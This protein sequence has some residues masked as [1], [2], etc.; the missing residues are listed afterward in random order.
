[1]LVS[2]LL[3]KRMC[4]LSRDSGVNTNKQSGKVV[5]NQVDLTKKLLKIVV[6]LDINK[7]ST[8]SSTIPLVIGADV[9]P[10]DEPWYYASV[11]GI[12][13]YITSNSRPDIQF[14]VH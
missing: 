7:N 5:H 1:M 10:F 13:M 2:L 9:T 3:L 4:I 6:M 12:L 11:V 14:E 8:P